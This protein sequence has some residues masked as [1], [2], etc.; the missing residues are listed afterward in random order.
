MKQSSAETV[1]L[2][3]LAW[4]AGHDDLLPVFLG[5]S[6]ASGDD[7][8]ARATEPAFLASVLEFLTMD[9]AW[10][11]RCC[12]ARGLAYETPMQALAVL[13]GRGRTHWT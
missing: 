1:A 13:Q 2:E 12:D 5:A 11:V 6:G 3:C 7:L 8:R 9:D 4:L 10:V